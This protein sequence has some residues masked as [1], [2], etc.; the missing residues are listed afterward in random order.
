MVVT[1]DWNR[2]KAG[3]FGPSMFVDNSKGESSKTVRFSPR[4]TT[5]GNYNVYIYF[6]KIQ[7]GSSRTVTTIFDGALKNEK[8]IEAAT[9]KVQGQTSGEW[10][11]LGTYSMKKDGKPFVE[12]SNKTSD[13]IVVADAVLFVPVRKQ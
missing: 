4:L 13:G 10:V 12:I 8:V 2:L 11:H 5:S 7:G 6:P 1:G 9:V 3:A